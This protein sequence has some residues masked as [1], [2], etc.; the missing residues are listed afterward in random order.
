M[1]STDPK[2][3]DAGADALRVTRLRR[4]VVYVVAGVALLIVLWALTQGGERDLF[5]TPPT[6]L[7]RLN[8]LH[9]GA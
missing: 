6:A 5:R 1:T 9:G 8:V 3:S 7:L 4:I 2:E